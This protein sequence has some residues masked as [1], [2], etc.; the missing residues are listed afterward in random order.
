MAF[1]NM[2]YSEA[3]AQIFGSMRAPRWNK[4][5]FPNFGDT[6]S[7]GLEINKSNKITHTNKDAI[8]TQSQI[9][10]RSQIQMQQKHTTENNYTTVQTYSKARASDF[11]FPNKTDSTNQLKT[12]S[13]EDLLND[14]RENPGNE[15]RT[16]TPQLQHRQRNTT[17]STPASPSQLHIQPQPQSSQV[18]DSITDKLQSRLN[19]YTNISKNKIPILSNNR[20]KKR[21]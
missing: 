18:L 10:E 21:T 1:E 13:Y 19:N 5:D 20:I 4:A 17:T 14:Q 7:K 15:Q 12:T 16:T 9:Q 2:S 11:F 3:H 8:K 6:M